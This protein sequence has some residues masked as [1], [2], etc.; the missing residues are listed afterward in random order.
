MIIMMIVNDYN[1]KIITMIII[2]SLKPEYHLNFSQNVL[3]SVV[4]MTLSLVSD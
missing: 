4:N 2:L 1:L 3:H